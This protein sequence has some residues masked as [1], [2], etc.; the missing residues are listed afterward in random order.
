MGEVLQKPVWNEP[1]G[2]IVYRS[3]LAVTL[4]TLV[5]CGCYWFYLAYCWASEV[6]RILKSERYDPTLVLVLSV[7]TLGI[8]GIVCECLFA[9]DLE[10]ACEETG[11]PNRDPRLSTWVISLNL[12]AM[13]TS[14]IPIAGLVIALP[15]GIW[16]TLLVQHELNKLALRI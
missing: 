4:L 3:L 14:L 5:T 13:A 10:R 12:V 15:L 16:A 7:C 9:R 2:L 8:A 1:Q 6:N 11:L